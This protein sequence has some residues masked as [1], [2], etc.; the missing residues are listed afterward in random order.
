MIP[1]PNVMSIKK[2]HKCVTNSSIKPKSEWLSPRN[3]G[4]ITLIIKSVVGTGLLALPIALHWSG[5]ILGVVILI[6]GIILQT[7]GLHLLVGGVLVYLPKIVCMV[8]RLGGLL[9]QAR[10]GLH[11]TLAS[12]R[13]P[14][15]FSSVFRTTASVWSTLY[16]WS[17]TL[18]I[19]WISTS[20]WWTNVTM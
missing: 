20:S 14:D 7:H 3:I 15:A 6:G 4:A 9:F 19:S 12:D 18:S 16:L 10:S 13:R 2:Y 17:W 1:M 8:P 5:M 11:E